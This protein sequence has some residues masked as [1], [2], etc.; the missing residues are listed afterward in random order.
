MFLFVC[1]NPARVHRQKIQSA[2]AR[3]QKQSVSP[4][5]SSPLDP[6]SRKTRRCG[7]GCSSQTRCTEH[8]RENR[9]SHRSLWAGTNLK[10]GVSRTR[11]RRWCTERKACDRL[12]NKF[13]EHYFRIICLA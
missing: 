11:S 9:I 3:P 4:S 7:C 8:M 12:L 13:I 5:M 6:G 1:I 2:N 10:A